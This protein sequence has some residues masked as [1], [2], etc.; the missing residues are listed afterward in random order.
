MPRKGLCL[1]LSKGRQ[2]N[3]IWRS[4]VYW[5]KF[6]WGIH[7]QRSWLFQCVMHWLSLNWT[8]K[9]TT[10]GIILFPKLIII[11]QGDRSIC[12]LYWITS[13]EI[14]KNYWSG[15]PTNDKEKKEDLL[16]QRKQLLSTTKSVVI[17]FNK[18]TS[19]AITLYRNAEVLDKTRWRTST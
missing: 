2:N 18:S 5:F 6:N 9:S 10:M 3:I 15:I 12:D 16:Q 19:G 11:I 4:R 1:L 14:T 17:A 13:A 8:R 7:C